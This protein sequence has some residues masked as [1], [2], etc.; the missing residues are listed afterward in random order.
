MAYAV[1]DTFWDK[2]FRK[3][4]AIV[5]RK[6]ADELFLVPVKGNLA[7]MQMIFT[8]NPVAEYIWNELD[9][10]NLRDI[11]NG[12]V[13]TF[14]VERERAEADVSDFITELLEADLIRE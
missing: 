2:I 4:D 9:T 13:T 7:D 10:K 8:L 5:S 14:Q 1:D 12:I 6:I 3:N 11:R